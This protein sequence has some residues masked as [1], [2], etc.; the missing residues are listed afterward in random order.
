M[1]YLAEGLKQLPRNLKH[2]TLDLH[3]NELGLNNDNMKFL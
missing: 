3:Y 1:E 2:L